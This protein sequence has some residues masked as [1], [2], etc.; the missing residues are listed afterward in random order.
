MAWAFSLW[1]QMTAHPDRL[2]ISPESEQVNP[3]WALAGRNADGAIA[4]LIVNPTDTPTSWQA[5]FAGRETPAS[6]TLYQVS[7]TAEGVQAFI[8]EAPA[9]EIED[10][11]VQLLI[12]RP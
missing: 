8:P 4:L 7:D 3:L 11:T 5:V 12:V 1:A 10:Y 6:A 9:A 2:N